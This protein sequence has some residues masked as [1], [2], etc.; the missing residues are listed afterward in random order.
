MK[1]V[2]NY[3]MCDQVQ[4]QV[5]AIMASDNEHRRGLHEKLSLLLSV[6]SLG[7]IYLLY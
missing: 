7:C 1:N 5:S 3:I 6:C 2:N 4:N